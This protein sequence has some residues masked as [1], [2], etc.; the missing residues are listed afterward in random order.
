MI[1]PCTKN[2]VS[3]FKF[4]DDGTCFIGQDAKQRALKEAAQR[5]L[6]KTWRADIEQTKKVR[7]AEEVLSTRYTHE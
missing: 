7:H 1:M 2:G 6:G 5:G 4:C 3:G